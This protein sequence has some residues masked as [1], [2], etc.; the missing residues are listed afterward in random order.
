MP[1]A[2]LILVFGVW[3]FVTLE[4]AC[5]KWIRRTGLYRSSIILA[6]STSSAI[7]AIC[8]DYKIL[9]LK[10]QQE[11]HDSNKDNGG[12][13]DSGL[14]AP[15]V[16]P[17]EGSLVLQVAPRVIY[18]RRDTRIYNK[19]ADRY[20]DLVSVSYGLS[21]IVRAMNTHQ[22]T[23]YLRKIE[24][25]GDIDVDCND[26]MEAFLSDPPI[27]LEAIARE[28]A[29]AKPYRRIHW[30]VYPS[31]ETRVD[32][33]GGE[34]FVQFLV[35]QPGMPGVRSRKTLGG[36]PSAANY[37]GRR[38]TD[39]KPKI[40]TTHPLFSDFITFNRAIQRSNGTGSWQEG[41]EP[42]L[43]K[44]VASENVAV[45]VQFSDRTIRLKADNITPP[46][47]ISESEWK[48][49]SLQELFYGLDR[50]MPHENPD[51]GKK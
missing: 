31:G 14:K 21:F 1:V 32:P 5:S 35:V 10:K 27:S 25:L 30:E 33:K 22:D 42:V 19:A 39:A 24:V 17:P 29:A 51:A 9:D 49:N 7:V 28:C 3:I 6:V 43:R 8:L 50:E 47:L 40:F 48:N 38:D 16:T 20:D 37:F 4:V 13:K 46:L 45:S 26:F 11:Q 44:E 2:T 23:K 34:R 18:S 36:E 41:Q 15:N 12:G